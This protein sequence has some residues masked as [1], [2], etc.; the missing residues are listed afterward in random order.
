MPEYS[1]V[2]EGEADAYIQAAATAAPYRSNGPGSN[3]T[4]CVG[5]ASVAREGARYFRTSVGSV[6]EGLTEKERESVFLILFIA[7]TD[8]A[9]HPAF[10]ETWLHNVPDRVLT[11]ELLPDELDH[12]RKLEGDRGL[13]R[14]KALFDYTYLLKACSAVG[15]PYIAM[16]EDDVIAL[17]GWYHRTQEALEQVVGQSVSDGG[18]SNCKFLAQVHSKT[19]L[20]S[21]QSHICGSST[22]RSS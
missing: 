22:P 4:L 7:H 2:R 5:I 16:L 10:T 1:S 8:P 9:V 13:F 20:T 12:I 3:K 21:C 19:Q 17:D 15:T 6:L 18:S 11:Y 14:E